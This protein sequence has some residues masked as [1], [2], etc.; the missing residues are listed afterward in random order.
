MMGPVRIGIL[1][2]DD[3]EEL[4]A[5][6]PYQVFGTARSFQPDLFD[7]RFVARRDAPSRV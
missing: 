3:V 5:V 2:F 1:L 4:D 6:G 7:V